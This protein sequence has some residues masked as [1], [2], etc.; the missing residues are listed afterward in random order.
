MPGPGGIPPPTLSIPGNFPASDLLALP[1]PSGLA[2][3]STPSPVACNPF[4]PVGSHQNPVPFVGPGHDL[5]A[6]GRNT[7]AMNLWELV[8]HNADPGQESYCRELDRAYTLRT[9]ESILDSAR[10]GFWVQNPGGP[11]W[12]YRTLDPKKD[13]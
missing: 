4:A 9:V 2:A 7:G 11:V 5:F 10:A 8:P 1:S 6:H 3:A 12:W 13:K